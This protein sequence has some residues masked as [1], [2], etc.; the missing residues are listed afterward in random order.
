MN[1][2]MAKTANLSNSSDKG[3]KIPARS[4]LRE[5]LSPYSDNGR[6]PKKRPYGKSN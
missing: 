5:R 2:Y 4:P 1:K 6:K 3:R